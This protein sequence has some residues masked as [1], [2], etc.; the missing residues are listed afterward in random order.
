VI[1]M[2]EINRIHKGDCLNLLQEIPDR[3]IDLVIIDPPYNIKKDTWDDIENYK[4][5]I[6]CVF[7]QIERVLKEN[8]SFYWFHSEMEVIADLMSWIKAETPFIFRQFIVWNKRF[9]GSKNKGFLDGYVVVDGL[10]NYQQMAEYCIY[11]TFQD[12]SGLSKV[13]N[14]AVYPIR[15]YIREE[16]IRAKGKIV[17]GDINR[18]LG[19]ATNGGGVASACLSLDKGKPTL[20]TE[21]HYLKI[22]AWLNDGR[23]YEFLRREY[24]DLRYTF[25]NQKNS[26][27]V[28]NY[29]IEKKQGHVTPKPLDLIKNIILHSSRKN[30]VVLDCF[31]G[32]GTVA[33]ACKQL[34]RNFIGIEKEQEFVDL[35]NRR[36]GETEKSLDM[37]KIMK[38]KM[39]GNKWRN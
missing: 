24:E 11:Y 3:S 4:H 21:E 7:L 35:C 36:L 13:M 34:D 17:L 14:S 29:D 1:S 2:L 26:H 9:S 28:W 25:N 23:E 31:M 33:V 15:E 5:W 37:F 30:Q 10:R 38:R 12:E 20:L 8:G 32:S 22:R 27:S 19:T 39:R 6:K 16:I 18:I